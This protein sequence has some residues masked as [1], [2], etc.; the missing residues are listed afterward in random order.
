M[1]TLY[2]QYRPLKFEDIVG[3][4]HVIETLQAALRKDKVAH[5]YVFYGARGTGKTTTA[6]VMA[7][8]LGAKGVDIIEIDAASNR[9]IDDIRA[10]RESVALSPAMG[11]KKVYII[12]EVHMLT[13]EAFA[14]LLKTLEEPVKHAVFILATTE[15]HK[16]PPTILSRCQVFRFKRASREDM[17]KR[18]TWILEQEKREVSREALDFVIGRCDGCYRDAESLLG[19]VLTMKEGKVELPDISEWLG[20]PAPDMIE[21]FLQALLE[22]RGAEAIDMIDAIHTEGV[23]AE[24]F[25]QEVVRAARDEAVQAAV[26]G[27]NIA[28]VK[29]LTEIIRAFLQ[30]AQDLA[31]VPEPNIALQLAALTVCKN[32]SPSL[33]LSREGAEQIT[34]PDKGETK[35]VLKK[36]WPK[37]VE[38]M[39]GKNPVASTFLRAIEPLEMDGEIVTLK[40]QYGLHRTFF[41]K[42][43]NKK[44]LEE[45][46]GTLLGKKITTRIQMSGDGVSGAELF[47]TA[48]EVFGR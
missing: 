6:R 46:L 23:D 13:K 19:Q 1:P 29:K 2:R 32:P 28:R 18:L 20:L 31:Y 17:A 48:K 27:N 15:L 47:E 3:Q 44:L 34:P 40:A 24:Q 35:G 33:T 26:A 9:G 38:Q 42:P 8:G 45:E 41:E 5:A 30:A 36:I 16:V 7:A 37:L 11:E 14:A 21:Q 25:V 22:G 43:E 39:K 4:E 12:D 10:L